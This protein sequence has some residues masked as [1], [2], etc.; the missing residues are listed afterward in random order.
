MEM[1]NAFPIRR[2]NLSRTIKTR[3]FVDPMEG[4]FM[5][6]EDVDTNSFNIIEDWAIE[7]YLAFAVEHEIQDGPGLDDAIR[8]S[9]GICTL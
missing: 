3:G 4:F 9:S 1:M 2:I 5:N 7:C 8:A 6:L